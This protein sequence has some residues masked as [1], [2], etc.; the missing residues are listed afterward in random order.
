MNALA[1]GAI[2]IHTMAIVVLLGYYATLSLVVLPWLSSGGSPEPGRTV[3]AMERRAMPWVLGSIAAFIV[4]GVALM[5]VHSG[6]NPDW[7][8]LII[9]KHVIVIAMVAL[10][11]VMDR[12][13]VPRL[14]GTWWTS[15]VEPATDV[16][17]LRPMAQASA[18]MG[19]LGALVLLLTAVA[20]LA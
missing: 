16:R 5:A 11:I 8:P 19:V 3:A 10:G 20:Q 1:V 17:D 7:T 4:T 6:A 9:V 14:D 15:A 18:V 12:V 13:L 2:W